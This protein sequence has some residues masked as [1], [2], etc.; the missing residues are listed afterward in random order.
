MALADDSASIPAPTA[1][2]KINAHLN[3]NPK[4]LQAMFIRAVMLAEQNKRDEAI[5]AFTDIT[6]KYPNLPEPYNN[7]AVLY[8]DQGQ[9]DKAR[10]ALESAIKTHPSYATAHENLGD[11]YAKMASEAYDKALQLDTSNTRAQTKLALIKDIFIAGSKTAL[12]PNKIADTT[13]STSKPETST[14]AADTSAAPVKPVDPVKS[15]DMKPDT[16]KPVADTKP[17]PEPKVAAEKP[18]N[19]NAAINNAVNK[20]AQAWSSK[21]VDNYL[22]AYAENFKTPNG[23]SRKAWAE[24][25]R[26]RINKPV[27]IQVEFSNLKIAMDGTDRAKASFKQS[28]HAGSLAQKTNKTLVMVKTNGKWLIE[29]E[30]TT[31]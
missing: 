29:Q 11:I 24:S 19:D 3:D 2:D 10:K 18:V 14:K 16:S 17:T 13:K 9:Y 8:A 1:L 28:Y 4:D 26:Q 5:K 30:L 21:S 20:W 22:A 25:R 23:E 7:L 31:H 27:K 6:E 15:T 12:S